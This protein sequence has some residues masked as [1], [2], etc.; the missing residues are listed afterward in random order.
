ME[1]RVVIQWTDTAKEQLADLPETD[2]YRSVLPA[3]R[4]VV[5]R[6][7]GWGGWL[8]R[9]FWINPRERACEQNGALTVVERL[10]SGS[11]NIHYDRARLS[12]DN[13]PYW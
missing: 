6:R 3:P 12:L 13:G 2:A 7:P 9:L 1:R 8:D 11:M 10:A 5:L 4:F